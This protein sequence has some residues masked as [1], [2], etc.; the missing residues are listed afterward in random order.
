[1]GT[2]ILGGLVVVLVCW[3]VATMVALA[4][5]RAK[6]IERESAVRM[7]QGQRDRGEW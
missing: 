3:N 2:A 1:M 6:R 5:E 4:A 7:L